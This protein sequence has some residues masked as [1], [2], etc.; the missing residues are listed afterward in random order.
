MISVS[1]V[2]ANSISIEKINDGV[3]I[4]LQSGGKD[5]DVKLLLHPSQKLIDS[6]SEPNVNWLPTPIA[7]DLPDIKGGVTYR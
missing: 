4:A 2:I 6:R 5:T 3:G 1:S 7:S